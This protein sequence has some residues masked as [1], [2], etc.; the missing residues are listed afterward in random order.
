MLRCYQR[1]I[2]QREDSKRCKAGDLVIVTVELLTY[3]ND[4]WKLQNLEYKVCAFMT[5][6]WMGEG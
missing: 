1:N 6:S 2:H 4:E 5:H 3:F